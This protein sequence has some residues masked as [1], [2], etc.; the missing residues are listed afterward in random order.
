MYYDLGKTDLQSLRLENKGYLPRLVIRNKYEGGKPIK[1]ISKDQSTNV[2]LKTSTRWSLQ[3]S[4]M[5]RAGSLQR[6]IFFNPQIIS[7]YFQAIS[8]LIKVL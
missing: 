8:L 5:C 2:S 1:V 3:R 7:L 6:K 4:K